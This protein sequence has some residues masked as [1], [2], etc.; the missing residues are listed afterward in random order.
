MQ[1]RVKHHVV[2]ILSS[3]LDFIVKIWML[4]NTYVVHLLY[5]MFMHVH[6]APMCSYNSTRAKR[7]CVLQ[8]IS[9][10][11]YLLQKNTNFTEIIIT[12]CLLDFLSDSKHISGRNDKINKVVCKYICIDM[13]WWCCNGK[14]I[15]AGRYN[16]YKTKV[17]VYCRIESRFLSEIMFFC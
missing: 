13:W 1:S 5:I 7:L 15:K 14:K 11:V 3:G 17:K 6:N 16:I 9:T 8:Y 12:V 2:G 10:H 4:P